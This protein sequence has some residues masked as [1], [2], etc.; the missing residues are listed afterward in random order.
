MFQGGLE[1]VEVFDKEESDDLFLWVFDDEAVFCLVVGG[2][3]L[4][5]GVL[6]VGEVDPCVLQAL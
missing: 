5:C 1:Y 2:D 3:G 4:E 6:G